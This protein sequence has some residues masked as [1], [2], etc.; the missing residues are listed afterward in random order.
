MKRSIRGTEAITAFNNLRLELDARPSAKQWAQ[1]QR[2]IKELEDKL[3]DAVM[4]RNETAEIESWKKTFKY[5]RKNQ[6]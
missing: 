2:E 5:A 4:M 1:K 6:S 3:H